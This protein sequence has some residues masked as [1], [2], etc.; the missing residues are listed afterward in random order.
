VKREEAISAA[1]AELERL[2][3]S[4]LKSRDP[5]IV[6]EN[7]RLIEGKNA[8]GWHLAFSL[9]VPPELEE[10]G[11]IMVEVHEPGGEVVVYPTL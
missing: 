10:H 2:G 4:N 3:V 5:M 8:R 9:I 1:L 7:A 6:R 11:M